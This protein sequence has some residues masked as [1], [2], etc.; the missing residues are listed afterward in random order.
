MLV[1]IISVGVTAVTAFAFWASANEYFSQLA[2]GANCNYLLT[3]Q[4]LGRSFISTSRLCLKQVTLR[5]QRHIC[6]PV[7]TEL[8]LIR[9]DPGVVC[10]RA[11][12]QHM[13]FGVL[14]LHRPRVQ[15]V[16]RKA[17]LF[18]MLF[19]PLCDCTLL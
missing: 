1:A 17:R 12:L 9:Y 7:A 19:V 6:L 10:D 8:Q 4:Y 2:F 18:K 5:P 15:N 16:L 3:T 14:L 13:L 11:Q